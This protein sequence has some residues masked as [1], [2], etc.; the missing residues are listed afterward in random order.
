MKGPPAPN[1]PAGQTCVLIQLSL[2]LQPVLEGKHQP[3][4]VVGC[5]L[6]HYRQPEGVVKLRDANLPLIHS[7]H[8]PA[9]E[10]SF[11]LP[12]LFLLLEGVHSG[13]S[14]FIP[15]HIAVVAFGVL[16]QALCAPGV[17]LDTPLGQFRYHRDLT[18]QFVQFTINGGAVGEVVLRFVFV[19][20]MPS[21]TNGI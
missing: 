5:G 14:L 17:F 11:G 8:E 13:L 18:E 15:R 10:V 9:N 21:S 2:N 4:I 19:P 7:K 20:E 1:E 6:L 12:L 3:P 16:L